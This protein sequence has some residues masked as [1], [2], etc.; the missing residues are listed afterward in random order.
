VNRRLIVAL[1]LIGLGMLGHALLTTTYRDAG[2]PVTSASAD[3]SA[4]KPTVGAPEARPASRRRVEFMI[5][6]A[7]LELY[8]VGWFLIILSLEFAAG[9]QPTPDVRDRFQLYAFCACLPALVAVLSIGYELTGRWR[10]FGWRQLVAAAC[11]LGIFVVTSL[12]RHAPLRSL[13]RLP[14]DLALVAGSTSTWIAA[15]ALLGLLLLRPGTAPAA[16]TGIPTGAAFSDWYAGQPRIPMP[17]PSEGAVVVVLK[18]NDYQCP[19]CKRTHLEYEPILASI[20]DAS[21]GAVRFTSMDYPLETECNPYVEADVHP[22]ACE[23]AAAVRLAREHGRERDMEQWL[24]AKQATLTPSAVIQAARDIGGVSDYLDRY[25]AVLGQI[26]ADVEIAHKL[27]V[28]G[29]PTHFVNG[30]RL[31]PVPKQDFEAAIRYE[32]ARGRVVPPTVRT[33]PG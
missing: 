1:A 16:S 3:R 6:G 32:L 11:V 30:V 25:P 26:R 10:D 27:G 19:P 14:S 20:G 13:R 7:P 15:S 12:V 5:K 8:G 18:F 2:S 31:M 22:A 17:V 21:P 23:A 9:R 29:T 33:K 4:T 28:P 24:W